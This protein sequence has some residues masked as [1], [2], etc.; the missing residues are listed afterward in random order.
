LMLVSVLARLIHQVND[1][2]FPVWRGQPVRS[3][4]AFG[5]HRPLTPAAYLWFPKASPIGRKVIH[6]ALRT[7]RRGVGAASNRT[8]AIRAA[9][10]SVLEVSSG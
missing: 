10:E 8:V 4:R 7:R 3:G 6:A 2:G 5:A 9:G 1:F